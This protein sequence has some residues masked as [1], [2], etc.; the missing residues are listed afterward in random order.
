[1]ERTLVQIDR[2]VGEILRAMGRCNSPAMFGE[3]DDELGRLR[4]EYADRE[5]M[6][7]GIVFSGEVFA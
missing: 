2:E 7:C 4:R 3:L 6:V 1:M 5:R